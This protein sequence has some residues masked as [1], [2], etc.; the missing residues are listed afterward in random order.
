MTLLSKRAVAVSSAALALLGLTWSA[1]SGSAQSVATPA[2]RSA[3]TASVPRAHCGGGD[4]PETALQGQVPLADRLTGR[5]SEGYR[6]NT[7]LVG[8]FAGEGSFI[9]SAFSG[10]CG[11]YGTANNSQQAHAGTVVV[12]DVGTAHPR[13]VRYL[14]ERS[15]LDVWESLKVNQARH[16]L[17]GEQK[18]GPGFA[19]YDVSTC[20]APQLLSQIDLAGNKGHAGNWAPDGK[21][22]YAGNDDFTGFIAV[23][24]SNARHPKSLLT[25][26]GSPGLVGAMHDLSVSADGT[27]AYLGYFGTNIVGVAA[28]SAHGLGYTPNGMAILDISDLQKRK[29]HPQVRVISNLIWTDGSTAQTAQILTIHGR[30]Y[31]AASDELGTKGVG[32]NASWLASCAQGSPP[33]GYT[34]LIDVTDERHPHITSRLMTE[35]QDPANCTQVVNDTSGGLFGYDAHYCAPDDPSNTKLIAC[36]QWQSGVRVYDVSNP[37]TPREVA[38]YNPPAHPGARQPGTAGSTGSGIGSTADLTS[39][40]IH[41]FPS[42]NEIGFSSQANGL[43]IIRLTHGVTMRGANP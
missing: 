19:V 1:P 33:F 8:G 26:T 20:A 35:A 14:A 27:R 43:Q 31:V 42:K 39:S 25:W 37:T 12:D 32:G 30:R 11:Y 2:V 7:T 41:F 24:V 36:S 10:N 3:G 22:F 40:D 34:R 21:T 9:Q 23:D 6:C 4:L 16:L 13:A 29:P 5:S 15:M 28:S 38:Y 17:A 18:A